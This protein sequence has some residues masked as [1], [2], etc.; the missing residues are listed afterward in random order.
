MSIDTKKLYLLLNDAAEL[1]WILATSNSWRRIVDARH[2][3]VCQPINQP[4]GHPDLLF[5]GGPEGANAQLMIEAVN[6]LPELLATID[7]Q[8][9]RIEAQDIIVSSVAGSLARHGVTEADDPGEAI[10]VLVADKDAEIARL[11][12]ENER[13][14]ESLRWVAAVLQRACQT[15]SVNER[16]HFVLEGVSRTGSEILDAADAALQGESK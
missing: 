3:P 9:A 1:P 2:T 4:D 7:A 16:D 6:A 5:A 15:G 10:D 13:L 14:L 11:R 8:A 12:G